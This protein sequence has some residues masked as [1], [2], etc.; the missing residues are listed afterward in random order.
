MGFHLS[1]TEIDLVWLCALESSYRWLIFKGRFAP[2]GVM[3]TNPLLLQ[4]LTHVDWIYCHRKWNSPEIDTSWKWSNVVELRGKFLWPICRSQGSSSGNRKGSTDHYL[5]VVGGQ[6]ISSI[7]ALLCGSG[8]TCG[9]G[10]FVSSPDVCGL[11]NFSE[12]VIILSGEL[13]VGIT[14]R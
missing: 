5:S 12:S 1:T 13:I 6:L 14:G 2:G 9:C 11:W 7:S 4:Q 8:T 10:D 3:H